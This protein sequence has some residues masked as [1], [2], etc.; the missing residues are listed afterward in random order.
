MGPV[1]PKAD[2]LQW[3]GEVGGLSSTGIGRDPPIVMTTPKVKG[4]YE[5]F[6]RIYMALQIILT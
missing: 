4:K 5:F 2:N 3:G 6:F 1:W